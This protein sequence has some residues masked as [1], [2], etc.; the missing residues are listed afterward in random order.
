LLLKQTNPLIKSDEDIVGTI[1]LDPIID[2]NLK[3]LF[4]NIIQIKKYN[5]EK[6]KTETE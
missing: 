6:N 2:F 3:E 5:D 4:D 1:L